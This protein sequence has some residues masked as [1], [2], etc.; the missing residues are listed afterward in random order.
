MGEIFVTLK[1]CGEYGGN[2]CYFKTLWRIWGKYL[3]LLLNLTGK[4][5]ILLVLKGNN[6]YKTGKNV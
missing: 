5:T 4:S 1:L 3:L 6:S 2:I